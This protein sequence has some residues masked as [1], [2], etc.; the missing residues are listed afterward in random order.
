MIKQLKVN[1]KQT[2]SVEFIGKSFL[3]LACTANSNNLVQFHSANNTADDSICWPN[4][5]C[6]SL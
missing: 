2:F 3:Q 1:L 4:Y 6:R 5:E